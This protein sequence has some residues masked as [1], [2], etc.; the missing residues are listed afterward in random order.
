MTVK[1]IK[2]IAFAL[3]LG[4]LLSIIASE[5]ILGNI[6]DASVE[7]GLRES[8]RTNYLGIDSNEDIVS[9]IKIGD[10]D[11]KRVTR[12]YTQT[13]AILLLPIAIFIAY[14]I[15]FY[16]LYKCLS[17][18]YDLQLS[19]LDQIIIKITTIIA[20]WLVVD[21]AISLILII[22]NLILS[23]ITVSVLH[24]IKSPHIS[25]VINVTDKMQYNFENHNID[26]IFDTVVSILTI[27]VLS[28]LSFKEIFPWCRNNRYGVKSLERET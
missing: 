6:V 5:Y 28:L 25:V 7:L 27:G 1:I 19:K 2:T 20:L 23:L 17:K 13:I 22:L 18:K 21:L 24:L 8:V 16:E 4:I 14:R 10:E 26:G 3:I 9:E 12:E 15:S 11:Y